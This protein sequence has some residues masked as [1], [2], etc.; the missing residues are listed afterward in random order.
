MIWQ[1]TADELPV[2]EKDCFEVDTILCSQYSNPHSRLLCHNKCIFTGPLFLTFDE[3]REQIYFYASLGT[4]GTGGFHC[5][6]FVGDLRKKATRKVTHSWGPIF[7]ALLSP[8]GQLLAL[9]RHRSSIE[10]LDTKTGKTVKEINTRYVSG[11]TAPASGPWLELR[12]LQWVNENQVR[13]M[14]EEYRDKSSDQIRA[15]TE[16]V[17]S[18]K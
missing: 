15:K 3:P 7:E 5:L 1:I 2:E 9:G 18:I 17:I 8:S 14:E 4:G 16:K 11:R 13:V 10:I 6:L 12:P